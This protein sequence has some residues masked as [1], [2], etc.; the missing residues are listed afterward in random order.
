M[1]QSVPINE[2]DVANGCHWLANW[3]Q[4]SPIFQDLEQLNLDLPSAG[5]A[6]W[7]ALKCLNNALNLN[8][9]SLVSAESL[10][11]G[12]Q[13]Y[14][15]FIARQRQIPTRSNWHDFFNAIIWHL[16][17]QTK[18]MFNKLHQQDIK[19]YGKGRTLRRDALTL[20]DECGVVLATAHPD[21]Q[22]LLHQHQWTELFWHRSELWG[23]SIQPFVL[24]HALYE[25]AFA[26][27]VGWCAKALVIQVDP[28]FFALPLV[29]QYLELDRQLA[30]LLRDLSHPKQ[31]CPLPVLGVPPWQ[32]E[33]IDDSYF[34]NTQYF[35]PAR[36]PSPYLPL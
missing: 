30:L 21:W 20:L 4:I 29:E 36:Q 8:E 14:E 16:F 1:S 3:Q 26:P 9:F 32:P 28:S 25:Q 13:S 24:G 6:H 17:P 10:D 19:K 23:Q 22:S 33:G 31:L 11:L 27:H 35:C 7:P 5:G 18:R 12:K 2:V 15:D 34:T